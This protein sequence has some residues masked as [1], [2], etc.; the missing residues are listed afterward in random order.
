LL[1]LFAAAALPA[2]AEEQAEPAGVEPE[3]VRPL[4]PIARRTQ[5]L[6]PRLVARRR[7]A[8]IRAFAR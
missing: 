6:E 7:H 8:R 4:V 1:V 5:R 2:F 3:F